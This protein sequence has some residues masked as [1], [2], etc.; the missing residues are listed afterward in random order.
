MATP[1]VLDALSLQQAANLQFELVDC[2]H[3]HFPHGS[4]LETGDL[5]LSHNGR[6]RQTAL[7][8]ETLADFFGAQ[9]C[10]LVRGAGTNAIRAGLESILTPGQPVLVHDAPIYPSTQGS[11]ESMGLK[12]VRADFNQLSSVQRA[13]K[14][15]CPKAAIVQHARQLLTDSYDLRQV[16]A[17]I[18]EGWDRCAI[19]VDDNYAVMKDPVHGIAAGAD[20][21]AFSL[22][23]LQGP[24]GIGCVV[25][26]RELIDQVHRR[27]CTGGMQV[28]GFEAMEAL[29]G[30]VS[31]P[32]L[33][34]VQAEQ[35]NLIQQAIQARIDQ[36][37][38]GIKNVFVVN[39]QSRVVLVELEQPIAQK[40]IA[41]A[42]KMGASPYPVGA[43]SKYE[44]P[45]LFY[46]ASRTFL[47][48]NEKGLDYFIRINPMRA[49][50]DTVMR[51]LT[52]A[53][54]KSK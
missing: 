20:L 49:G 3:R 7:V 2:I 33:L 21:S 32:V 10:A 47:A 15:H 35:T 27:N 11:I 17:A 46:K 37:G 34:A 13:V 50:C 25:G 8:E 5:G 28:Q 36:G 6:P 4:F 30:L 9:A 39:M 23:K 52:E 43:E 54:E 24:A 22:F 14:T 48:S 16:I 53:I 12:I 45:A 1:G 31:A 51:I 44:I 19:L 42:V 40:V 41:Q 26:K 18:R 38:S 29:R